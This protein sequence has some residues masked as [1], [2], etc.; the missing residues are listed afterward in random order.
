M[1]SELQVTGSVAI[2]A[3]YTVTTSYMCIVG[4]MTEKKVLV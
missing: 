1:V 2:L 4:M 3:T